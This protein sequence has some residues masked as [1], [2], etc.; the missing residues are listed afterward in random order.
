MSP[1]RN[2]GFA[3]RYSGRFHSTLGDTAE[4]LQKRVNVGEG[5]HSGVDQR[6]S[7]GWLSQ[8]CHFYARRMISNLRTTQLSIGFQIAWFVIMIGTINEH[9]LRAALVAVSTVSL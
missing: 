2:T 8:A 4:R 9:R 3:R 1:D 7:I 6:R 5:V